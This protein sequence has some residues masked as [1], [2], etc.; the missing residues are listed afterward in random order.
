MPLNGQF[1]LTPLCNFD[2]KMCY[3]HLD[4]DQLKGREILSV[5]VWKE[6]MIQ[7]WKAGM[8]KAALTGGECLAYPGF[9]ELFLHLQSL[10]C[11]VPVMTNGLL[12]DE[13]RVEFF[14]KHRPACLQITLYGWNDD[15][16]ERVTGRRAFG[17]VLENVRRAMDAG[18]NVRLTVTPN[19]FLG[20][21]VLETV[22]LG[23]GLAKDFHVNSAIFVPREETGRSHQ[24]DD[25]DPDQYI[26]IARVM[27]EGK[28]RPLREIEAEKL[29]LIGGPH[30]TCAG[31][32]LRC[33]GGRSSF[34]ITWEKGLSHLRGDPQAVCRAGKAAGGFMRNRPVL[35]T[36]RRDADP[37]M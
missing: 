18:L 20:E 16:Y 24:R 25:P 28:G 11:E 9:D 30:H 29:P 5:P 27:N 23:R 13:K 22:R 7:A 1:E 35:R 26:R 17:T 19:R 36:A 31:R 14:R 4:G 3:V 33:G 8:V 12:L 10:G 15:V 21:D 2:C 34:V 32:G 6:L 37:R